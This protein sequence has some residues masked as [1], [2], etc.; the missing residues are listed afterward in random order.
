MRWD[1]KAIGG[2]LR[3]VKEK[4]WVEGSGLGWVALKCIF[5]LLKGCFLSVVVKVCLFLCIF[6]FP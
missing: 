3:K 2:N 5:S 6:C 4:G 1:F